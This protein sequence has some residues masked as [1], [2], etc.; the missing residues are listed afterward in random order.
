M[1]LESKDF[2]RGVSNGRAKLRKE[3]TNHFD[4]GNKIH[5]LEK[6]INQLVENRVNNEIKS[7]LCQITERK[8]KEP[9]WRYKD[10]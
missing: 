10:Y 4:G 5:W 7:R 9:D 3:V 2:H 8:N 1:S 6:K